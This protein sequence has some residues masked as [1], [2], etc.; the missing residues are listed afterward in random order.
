MT[1]AATVFFIDDEGPLRIAGQQTLDLAGID[2]ACF[3]RAEAALDQIDTDFEGV[4]V[5]D[6]RMPGMG[7]VALLHAVLQ[8][9][10]Q[11]P[12]ILVTGH[13]DVDLAVSMMRDGAYDFIEKPYAPERLVDAVHR[14]I[15]MRRLTMENRRL[16]SQV[17]S[18]LTAQVS[19]RGFSGAMDRM[20]RQI[21]DIAATDANVLIVGETGTGKGLAAQALHSGSARA[22]KPFIAINCA[23]LPVDGIESELFGHQA[24]AHAAAVRSRIGRFEHAQRGTLFLDEIDSLPMAMQGK[25]LHAVENR[26]INPLGS[27]DPIAL[28]VRFVA[29]S[30][31]NLQD[32][33]AKGT[34]REDLLYRLNVVT[35]QMP[36]LA[37]RREDVPILFLTF[38]GQIADRYDLPVPHVPGAT[39][40]AVAARDWPG[41]ARELRNA[42]ERF[43]LGLPEDQDTGADASQSLAHRMADHE[44]ALIAASLTAHEG[45]LKDTY[46]ALGI[47]R[48]ALYEK[49]VRYDLARDSFTSPDA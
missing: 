24:G 5:T 47:S 15:A 21:S 17:Q 39:L 2:C 19:L 20:R 28:D 13:G 43:V 30:K 48:K 31:T 14:A 41:N 10:P 44:R 27:H 12:V 46:E 36:T 33:V 6:L 7:G 35:L 49:M 18:P 45:R 1:E 32:A 34:F 25:L 26:L 4:I 29:A 23:A 42:A 38:V 37:A 11:I 3:E 8:K 22:D 16:R 9:D 40:D